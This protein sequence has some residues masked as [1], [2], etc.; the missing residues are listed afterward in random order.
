MNA[1]S[2]LGLDQANL[3]IGDPAVAAHL[4]YVH[5]LAKPEQ[6]LAIPLGYR[7]ETSTANGHPPEGSPVSPPRAR[8]TEA[9]LRSHLR[10][11][12]RYEPHRQ[13]LHLVGER[14]FEVGR[15]VADLN[16][17]KAGERLL[18]EYP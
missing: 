3:V 2:V 12:A 4:L 18:E 16:L 11:R 10:C 8:P 6:L 9:D 17:G 15:G 5:R 13:R 1:V 14:R 7:P